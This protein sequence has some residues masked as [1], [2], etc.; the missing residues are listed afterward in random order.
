[1]LSR[2]SK[3]EGIKKLTTREDDDFAIALLDCW[4]LV[5]DVLTFYQERIANEAFLRTAKERQ[6][7]IEISRSIGYELRPGVAAGTRLAFTLEEVPGAADTA[8]IETGTKVQSLPS[9]NEKPQTFETIEKIVAYREWNTLKPRV[10]YTR[11]LSSNDV[12]FVV[13]QVNTKLKPGDL[14]LLVIQSS[15]S[16]NAG[17]AAT[18]TTLGKFFR[19][20]DKI[21]VDLSL[22]QTTLYTYDPL[23]LAA[24]QGAPAVVPDVVSQ[25]S[26][27]NE[28]ISLAD[29]SESNLEEHAAHL[30][31]QKDEL[32]KFLNVAVSAKE[33]GTNGDGLYYFEAKCYIFGHNAPQFKILP[34]QQE[35][36]GKETLS[37]RQ[38]PLDEQQISKT[39]HIGQSFT[40]KAAKATNIPTQ[41]SE[42]W[43]TSKNNGI[44]KKSDGTDNSEI[45]L[46]NTYPNILL[47][48]WAVFQMPSTGASPLRL[49]AH[50]VSTIVEKTLADFGLSNKV[51]GI[52]VASSAQADGDIRTFTR[53]ET[54]VFAASRKLQL[55]PFRKPTPLEKSRI[56][57]DK[58]IPGLRVGQYVAISGK[59]LAATDQGASSSTGSAKSQ[60]AKIKKIEHVNGYTVL[61]FEKD[62]KYTFQRET[63]TINANLAAATHGETKSEVIG[64]GDPSK[65]M[66][67][68]V[69]KQ[70]PLTYTASSMEGGALSTLQ[71]TVSEILWREVPNLFDAGPTEHVYTVRMDDDQQS[72]IVFGDG[73]RGARPPA[74]IENIRAKFRTGIGKEGLLKEGQLSLLM[75]RPLGVKGVTNPEATNGADDPEGI[76]NARRNA[77]LK[78]LAMGRIVSL[79]DVETFA[80]AFAGIAK[81]DAMWIWNGEKKVVH[82][83]VAPSDGTMIGLGSQVYDGLV[84]SIKGSVDPGISV[85]VHSFEPQLFN[86]EANLSIAGEFQ[87]ENVVANI[88]QALLDKFSFDARELGQPVRLDEI[89]S[90]IQKVKGVVYV[91]VEKLYRI[92]SAST[93]GKNKKART[94]LPS[95]PSLLLLS[96][97]SKGSKLSDDS[98]FENPLE[99]LHT[100]W[101]KE[102][103]VLPAELLIINS[104]PGG[105]ILKEVTA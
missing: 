16:E 97:S 100:R 20:I 39:P 67:E 17:A 70:K 5:G 75:T 59:T 73:I 98:H 9:P 99:S 28:V 87:K 80:R 34:G 58:I 68:F 82:V 21:E 46:D 76:D 104:A 29:L 14:L 81:A 44:Y 96:S 91:D 15:E 41:L 13:A 57:L 11:Q 55:A 3:K 86:L 40:E 2:I 56:E 1:M 23:G 26:V 27:E 65:K 94:L 30:G 37:L 19:I 72:K 84:N 63:V 51:T 47:Q 89:I 102:R 4:A 33:A 78:L 101:D 62:L 54:T 52:S 36:E 85:V 79:K 105:I 74:G 6:S 92:V 25:I 43:V 53:R 8:I 83:T 24:T 61:E 49:Q 103:G 50:Q 31:W 45:F 48:T 32:A 22:Q 71:I 93:S 90:T 10:H 60:I 35:G 88:R 77:P 42:E 69:L 7:L 66:Q 95:L 12:N 64:G 18:A 38:R